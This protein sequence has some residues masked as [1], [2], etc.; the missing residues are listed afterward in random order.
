MS[1][2]FSHSLSPSFSRYFAFECNI[3]IHTALMASSFNLIFH[4]RNF[5]SFLPFLQAVFS[6]HLCIN[7][8]RQ[9]AKEKQG[10]FHFFS[11]LFMLLQKKI[12]C[13][14]L[15]N[16]FFHLFTLLMDVLCA[17]SKI[18]Q[19]FTAYFTCLYEHKQLILMKKLQINSQ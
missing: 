8:L 2:I 10:N 3:I 1:P 5:F 17:F 15:F 4:D 7:F 6:T 18:K 19:N 9:A 14:L 12:L 13:F 11:P 16:N